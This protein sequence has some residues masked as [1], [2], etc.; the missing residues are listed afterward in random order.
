MKVWPVDA[1]RMTFTGF[2]TVEKS[3]PLGKVQK[4][5]TPLMH[6]SWMPK[7]AFHWLEG[8]GKYLYLI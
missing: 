2:R 8:Q 3:G 1:S 5:L 6:Q 4:G 7:L